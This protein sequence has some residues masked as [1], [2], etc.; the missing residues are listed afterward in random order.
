MTPPTV[1]TAAILSL[2]FGMAPGDDEQ[3]LKFS[4]CPAAVRNTMQAEAKGAKIET[5]TREKESEDETVYWADVTI[6]GRLYSIGVLEDGT[7][8]RCAEMN[9]RRGR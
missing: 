3:E 5:V 2:V 9:L 7:C 1:L 8:P 4:A 6:G